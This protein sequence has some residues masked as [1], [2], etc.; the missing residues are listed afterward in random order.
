VLFGDLHF[1]NAAFRSP[2]PDPRA[3]L[4]DPIPRRQPWPFE[5]A[6][7]EIMSGGSALVREM[8]EIRRKQ[9]RPTC[10]PDEVDRVA[11]LYCGWM[12]LTAWGI[13][14]GRRDDRPRRERLTTYVRNAARLKFKR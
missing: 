14:P 12:A 10:E 1:G 6:Y 11:A 8:A 13:Q 9:G 7:L 2:P 5:P 3:V 4:F